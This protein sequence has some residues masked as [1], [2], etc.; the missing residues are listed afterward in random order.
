MFHSG[1]TDRDRGT[2]VI[3]N[4]VIQHVLTDIR[5]GRYDGFPLPVFSYS[6]AA[7]QDQRRFLGLE[8]SI[9]GIIINRVAFQATVRRALQP[10][11][12]LYQLNV[13]PNDR[14]QWFPVNARG[15]VIFG[16]Q[17]R[18]RREIM[19]FLHGLQAGLIKVRAV[20]GGKKIER[21]LLLSR[22]SL[23][24]LRRKR[25]FSDRKYFLGGGLVFQELD[26]EL[27]HEVKHPSRG[28]R[29]RLKYRYNYH[30]Q[31]LL[32]EQTD[33]EIVLTGILSD[34]INAGTDQYKY[35]VVE[36]INGRRVRTLRDFARE[37]ALNQHRYISIKFLDDPVPLTLEAEYLEQAATRIAGK[38]PLQEMGRVR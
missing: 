2:Y 36:T 32:S 24:D 28:V 15:D 12:V 8:R 11:D 37:W 27:V 13:N 26:Y 19:Q 22:N 6:P 4:S 23:F 14:S 25:V 30:L 18:Q 16:Q 20:R 34:P 5:D 9:G 10:G 1:K 33:R 17:P 35:S 29:D 38:F 21:E 31:D 3:P 7:N